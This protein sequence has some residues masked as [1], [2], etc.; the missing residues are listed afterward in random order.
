MRDHYEGTPFALDQKGDQLEQIK[1]KP[2]G[3]R[4]AR[5]LV[6]KQDPEIGAEAQGNNPLFPPLHRVRRYAHS[7]C[8]F[9]QDTRSICDHCGSQDQ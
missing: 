2:H 6:E 9:K 5:K 1:G 4:T 8:F 3:Q 7:L